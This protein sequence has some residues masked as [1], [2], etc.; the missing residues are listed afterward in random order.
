M[1]G[2]T[3]GGSVREV[4][5]ELQFQGFELVGG[6]E[7]EDRGVERKFGLEGAYLRRCHPETVLLPGEG[8]VGVWEPRSASAATI[9]SACAGGTT[10]SSSPCITKVGVRR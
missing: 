7:A 6:G 3:S 1:T 9:A 5:G 10:V 4:L 2:G 8:Q